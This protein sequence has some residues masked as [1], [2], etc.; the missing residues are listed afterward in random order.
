MDQVM[1]Q[2]MDQAT[3]QATDQMAGRYHSGMCCQ[4]GSTGT[5]MHTS[6]D[7]H[8]PENCSSPDILINCRT[9]KR[10]NNLL[11]LCCHNLH[12]VHPSS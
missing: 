9:K 12:L 3:D 5:P 6:I 8:S 7:N 4:L 1:D 11:H 10:N 2:V